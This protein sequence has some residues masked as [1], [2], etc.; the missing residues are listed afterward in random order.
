MYVF[1]FFQTTE[2]SATVE[3]NAL[4]KLSIQIKQLTSFILSESVTADM[5]SSSSSLMTNLPSELI[6]NSSKWLL[7]CWATDGSVATIDWQWETFSPTF[8]AD[9]RFVLPRTLLEALRS[10]KSIGSSSGPSCIHARLSPFFPP[11]ATPA[12]C[13]RVYNNKTHGNVRDKTARLRWG[14]DSVKW[15][16]WASA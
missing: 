1:V 4:F 3:V 12:A 5:V 15:C 11:L 8:C 14:I 13:F 10:S 16:C 9:R 7:S 6:S 2:H